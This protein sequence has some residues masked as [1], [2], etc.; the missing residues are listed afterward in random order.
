MKKVQTIISIE[1]HQRLVVKYRRYFIRAWCGECEREVSMI[2]PQEAARL[3]GQ[4]ITTINLWIENKR[5]HLYHHEK[6][7]P[8][9]ICLNSLCSI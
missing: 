3:S 9:F 1:S 4:D 8:P 5:F 2:A 6:E 7:C